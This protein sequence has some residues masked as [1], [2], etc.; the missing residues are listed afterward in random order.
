VECKHVLT[1]V[2]KVDEIFVQ[3]IENFNLKLRPYL[4]SDYFDGWQEDGSKVQSLLRSHDGS[5]S[6]LVPYGSSLH[7][8]H[9]VADKEYWEEKYPTPC[10][11]NNGGPGTCVGTAWGDYI[12]L[13]ILLKAAGVNIAHEQRERGF[14][15]ELE[16]QYTNL[17]DTWSWPW[18][19]PQ[20]RQ[21]I[22][23][24]PRVAEAAYQDTISFYDAFK[25][26]EDQD[27][28]EHHFF[29]INNC[30]MV[31]IRKRGTHGEFDIFRVLMEVTVVTTAFHLANFAVRRGLSKVYQQCKQVSHVYYLQEIATR[32]QTPMCDEFSGADAHVIQSA[33]DRGGLHSQLVSRNGKGDSVPE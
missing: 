30:L 28:P 8:E 9:H 10:G 25:Y 18:Q 19:L 4:Y 16:V 22:V 23:Y 31:R 29:R 14:V 27:D 11:A 12:S 2:D 7:S 24:V 33:L 1:N 13:A 32:R 26:D 20:L 6:R 3:G 17:Q 5:I 15:M 21:K